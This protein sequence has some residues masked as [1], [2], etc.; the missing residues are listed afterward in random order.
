MRFGMGQP[1]CRRIPVAEY[2]YLLDHGS[3][4]L[5]MFV[6]GKGLL[7]IQTI[8]APKLSKRKSFSFFFSI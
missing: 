7:K 5:E 3:V 2:F 1:I 8:G 4:G 6:R